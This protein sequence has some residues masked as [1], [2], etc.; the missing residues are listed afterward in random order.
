MHIQFRGREY[1]V[2]ER[3]PSGDLRLKDI[4]FNESRSMPEGELIDAL[5]EGDF[6]FLGDSSVT[7]AQR[8]MFKTFVDDLNMLDN[9]DPRKVETKRRYAYVKA[10]D[11]LGPLNFR[12]G[13]VKPLIE[14]VHAEIGDTKEKPNWKTV[15]YRWYRQWVMSDRDL[16]SLTPQYDKR[17]NTSPKFSSARKREGDK[18]DTDEKQRAKEVRIIIDEVILE[19]FLTEQ[20]LSVAEVYDKLDIRIADENRHRDPDDQLPI[21]HKSSLYEII[22]KLDEYEKDAARYGKRFADQK[23]RS[24]KKGADLTRPLQR[25]EIDDTKLD[26]F[27][28]DPETRL[29]VGRPTLT[30]AI[31]CY[32]RMPL[33]FHIGFDGPGYLAVMQC[34]L[35]AIR[36]KSYLKTLFPDV[37]NEWPT[38]GVPEEL[39]V[40]NGPAYINDSLTDACLQIGTVLTQ[41]RVKHPKDKPMVEN[42]FGRYNKDLLHNQP[43]TTFSNVIEKGEYDPKKNAIISFDAL[44]KM[45]HIWLVDI[46]SRSLHRGHDRIPVTVWEEGVKD[47]PPYLPRRVDDLRILIGHVEFRRIGPSGVELFTL[48]YNCDEL[49]PLRG[50]TVK[51]KYDPKDISAVYVYNPRTD[52]HIIVPALDQNYAKG[53]SLWQHEVIKAYVKNVMKEKL[54]IDALRRAKIKIQQIVDKEW[55]KSGASGTKIRMARWKGIRQPDYNAA[56]EKPSE[57]DDQEQA[58]TAS[59]EDSV[60]LHPE[61]AAYQSVSDF[62]HVV[63]TRE[64][65][66]I[67]NDESVQPVTTVMEGAVKKNGSK[68]GHRRLSKKPSETVDETNSQEEKTEITVGTESL[69]AQD[70][71]DLNMTGFSSSYDLPAMEA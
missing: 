4:A 69:I 57:Q 21:P 31:D 36:S 39:I 34:L 11:E 17:G 59:R 27:V 51:V 26:L 20:R 71:D 10:L 15:C 9:D 32:T 50:E 52:R 19:H 1:V 42:S 43:G 65:V 40:D 37:E 46:Y 22:K 58:L 67:Q 2:E 30:Y 35:H 28:V 5:F 55:L 38:Y 54:D 56:V 47:Y 66:D 53:L 41:C 64:E 3:L 8:K 70:D 25:V 60:M 16:R 61:A 49:L 68:N 33:G 29:P 45:V 62:G 48:H 44:L 63:S 7:L 12:R 6:E 18:F 23:H 13:T 14:K 24:N